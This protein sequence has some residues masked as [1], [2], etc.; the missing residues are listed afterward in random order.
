MASAN[1]NQFRRRGH[2]LEEYFQLASALR[3]IQRDELRLFFFKM[4]CAFPDDCFYHF[5][6]ADRLGS[7]LAITNQAFGPGIYSIIAFDLDHRSQHR[8]SALRG[9]LVQFFEECAHLPATAPWSPSSHHGSMNT[10]MIP[11]H[12][13]GLSDEMS[14]KRSIRTI[15]GLRVRMPSMASRFTSASPHPPPIVPRISPHAVTTI[16]APTSR[17]VDLFVETI[18]AP[19]IVSLLSRNSFTWW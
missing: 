18:V 16:W 9:A 13:A 12:T 19:A 6:V 4:G 14:S 10:F 7:D 1:Q 17:G 11:P 2:D 5:G 15:R 3:D 8:G